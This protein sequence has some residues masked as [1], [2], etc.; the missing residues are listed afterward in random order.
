MKTIRFITPMVDEEE[1]LSI[2]RHTIVY[3]DDNDNMKVAV[4]DYYNQYVDNSNVH[5]ALNSKFVAV[6]KNIPRNRLNR[7]NIPVIMLIVNDEDIIEEV[8][9]EG[10]PINLF[11]NR[12]D[13]KTLIKRLK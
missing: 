5:E 6:Y 7:R 9:Y 11:A 10:Y 2:T 8:N 3:L 4:P 1:K 13:N 12:I